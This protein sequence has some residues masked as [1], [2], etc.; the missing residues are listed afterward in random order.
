LSDSP[1]LPP[2]RVSYIRIK[3]DS[4]L[5]RLPQIE[6]NKNQKNKKSYRMQKS[7]RRI[8]EFQTRTPGTSLGETK[9]AL[10]EKER[11]M[12]MFFLMSRRPLSSIESLP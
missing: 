5:V 12:K 9:G 2:T 11:I 7:G 4:Q 1:P 6:Y 3:Y 10:N 8:E